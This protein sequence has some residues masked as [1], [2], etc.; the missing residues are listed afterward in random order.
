M[1]TPVFDPTTTALAEKIYADLL[2]NAVEVSSTGVKLSTDPKSLAKLSF[3]LATSF[4]ETENELN[5]ENLPKNQDFKLD[6]SDMAA[7]NK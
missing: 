4:K 2:R 1:T 5:A 6:V 3:K 7:W